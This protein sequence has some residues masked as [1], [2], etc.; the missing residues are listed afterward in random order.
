MT[1]GSRRVANSSE[2]EDYEPDPGSMTSTE[3]IES[4]EKHLEEVLNPVIDRTEHVLSNLVPTNHPNNMQVTNRKQIIC[5]AKESLSLLRSAA[6]NWL[7]D[8]GPNRHILMSPILIANNRDNI[9][10]PSV[11]SQVSSC[12]LNL[13]NMKDCTSTSIDKNLLAWC[14]S[15]DSADDHVSK[16]SSILRQVLLLLNVVK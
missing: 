8:G 13:G 1:F 2:I 9:S 11:P 4:C 5:H 10:T 15:C 14:H 7:A 12:N 3:E 16:E 6:T